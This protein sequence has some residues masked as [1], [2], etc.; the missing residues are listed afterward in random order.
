MQALEMKAATSRTDV[1]M[2]RAR[3]IFQT[4]TRLPAS[5]QFSR[6]TPKWQGQDTRER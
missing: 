5:S 1:S 2:N 3:E 4:L 6:V